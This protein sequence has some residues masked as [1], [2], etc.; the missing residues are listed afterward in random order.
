MDAEAVQRLMQPVVSVDTKK[1]EPVG[2]FRNHGRD[3]H[4][5][6]FP[7]DVNVH[8][9]PDPEPG[10][11]VPYG[12][13][14]MTRNAGWVSVGAGNDMAAFAVESLRQWWMDM[15]RAVYPEATRQV[16]HAPGRLPHRTATEK[17]LASAIRMPLA[18]GPQRRVR[19]AS[20]DFLR[21]EIRIP[22]D[23]LGIGGREVRRR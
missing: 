17:A 1:K 15:G 11:A 13:H 22:G 16:D 12:V 10:R 2:R 23:H 18:R 5:K 20:G 21:H 6:G 19:N 8:D 14:D 9:L 3:W 7:E 4:A